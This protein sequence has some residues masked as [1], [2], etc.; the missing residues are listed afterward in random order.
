MASRTDMEK[1]G[2]SNPSS[3]GWQ[4]LP[5]LT[6]QLEQEAKFQEALRQTI[7]Q[8]AQSKSSPE[9]QLFCFLKAPPGGKTIAFA[10]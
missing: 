4:H 8:L 1:Q 9:Q 10:R 6:L 5:D 2:W 3:T 7:R